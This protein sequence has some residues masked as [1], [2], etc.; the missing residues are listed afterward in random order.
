LLRLQRDDE[1]RDEVI[2]HNYAA[3]IAAQEGRLK[4]KSQIE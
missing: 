1:A 4:K 3:A 2:L